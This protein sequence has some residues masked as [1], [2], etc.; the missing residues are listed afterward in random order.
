MQK[1]F[2]FFV[3]G[4]LVTLTPWPVHSR[5][6][7]NQQLASANND[8]DGLGE[9]LFKVRVLHEMECPMVEWGESDSPRPS[10]AQLAVGQTGN[11]AYQNRYVPFLALVLKI[12]WA[13]PQNYTCKTVDR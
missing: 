1:L 13:S 2:D 4:G 5:P 8:L 12:R 9:Q 7:G 6:L 11:V 3:Y 10:A